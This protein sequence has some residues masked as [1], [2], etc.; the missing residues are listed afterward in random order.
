MATLTL[1]LSEEEKKVIKGF[2]ILKKKSVS[3]VVL[4]S[5]LEK[6]EDEKDYELALMVVDEET[7]DISELSSECGIDYEAL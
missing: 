2:S 5:I 7:R 6:I 3:A 4:E 1:R